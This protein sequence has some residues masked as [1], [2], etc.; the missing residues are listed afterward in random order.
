MHYALG[1]ILINGSPCW[2]GT[3]AEL[4]VLRTWPT[5]R[6]IVGNHLQILA[7]LSINR[8]ELLEKG[9]EII[10]Q[11]IKAR[12]PT[13]DGIAKLSLQQKELLKR[14]IFRHGYYVGDRQGF[15]SDLIQ[16]LVSQL[17][18]R[19]MYK[20][21]NTGFMPE[22]LDLFM[23]SIA[24]ESRD[25]RDKAQTLAWFWV[26]SMTCTS[27]AGERYFSTH[28]FDASSS[29]NACV[30]SSLGYYYPRALLAHLPIKNNSLVHLFSLACQLSLHPEKNIRA[31]KR[32]LTR[33]TQD[34][35]PL[36]IALARHICRFSTEE[37]RVLLHN[38]ARH[39]ERLAPPLNWG[40]QYLIRGDIVMND[41]SILTLDELTRDLGMR[42]LPY[43]DEM[44]EETKIDWDEV[45]NASGP[46]QLSINPLDEE[47]K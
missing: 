24:R 27:L 16:D 26:R 4:V 30:V 9:K 23:F 40:L 13:T 10:K 18:P 44:P 14:L 5:N 17:G 6:Q 1:R 11:A 41:G 22:P 8:D 38:L 47:D 46:T 35:E 32:A 20:F 25:I 29:T 7:S 21:V 45:L 31:F 36:W 42:D 19:E 39:P 43:L 15:Q 37:D 33:Y 28:L 2:P 34:L 12:K 3:P